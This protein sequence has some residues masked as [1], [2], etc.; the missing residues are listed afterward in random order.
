[1]RLPNAEVLRENVGIYATKPFQ[2]GEQKISLFKGT[3]KIS[4]FKGTQKIPPFEKSKETVPPFEKSKETVPP[5]E[6][7]GL[8]GIFQSFTLQYISRGWEGE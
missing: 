1:M 8:G 5:F 3:Q 7:G 2:R 4:L 6:K